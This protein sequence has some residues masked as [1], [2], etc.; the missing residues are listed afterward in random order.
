MEELFKRNRIKVVKKRIIERWGA[1]QR[2]DDNKKSKMENLQSKQS[3]NFRNVH[4]HEKET[5]LYKN[6]YPFC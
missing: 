2:P 1:A 4:E 6:V 5:V 3:P